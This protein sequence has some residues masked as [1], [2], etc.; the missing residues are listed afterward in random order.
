MIH[1]ITFRTSAHATEDP[2]RVKSAL[3]LFLPVHNSSAAAKEQELIRETVTKGYYQNPIIIFEAKLDRSKDCLS[4][5]E[6]LKA[7]MRPEDL[8]RLVAELPLRVD[9]DCNLHIRFDKQEAYTGKMKFAGSSDSINMRI[10][11]KSYPAR[12]DAAI[13]VARSL[14]A[15]ED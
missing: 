4:A 5:I 3:N 2:D 8:S 12:R 6:L 10:K 15:A 13:N 11:L 7:K 9:E 1:H 14:F